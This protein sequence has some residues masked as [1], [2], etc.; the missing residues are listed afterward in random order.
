VKYTLQLALKG[1]RKLAKL[2]KF[3][4]KVKESRSAISYIGN[5][6]FASRVFHVVKK[7][8]YY[9]GILKGINLKKDIFFINLHLVLNIL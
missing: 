8:Y 1:F 9:S 2:Q 4:I 5:K 3:F 7:M 6:L